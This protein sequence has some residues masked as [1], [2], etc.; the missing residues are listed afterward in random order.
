VAGG[1]E[2]SPAV[3][4][5]PAGPEPV[6]GSAL[7]PGPDLGRFLRAALVLGLSA[8]SVT[9]AI[10]QHLGASALGDLIAQN[11][12]A[13]VVRQRALVATLLVGALAGAGA[14]GVAWRRR[15]DGLEALERA[16]RLSSPGIVAALVPGLFARE[17]WQG[18]ELPLLVTVAA[19]S[20]LLERLLRR[21]FVAIPDSWRVAIS[22]ALRRV[23]GALRTGLPLVAVLGAAAYYLATVGRYTLV[24]HER[25]V[26]MSSDLAEFDNLFFNALSGH[27]FR[28]P[29]I[30]G[31]LENWS[32]LKVHAEFGLYLLL[33]FYA[34]K[35]GPEALLLIQTALVA[36][37]SIPVYLLAARRLGRGPG[38]VFAAAFLL[39]PV[40]QRPNFY[41]FHFTPLG[42][43]LVAWV[44]VALDGF[45]S[46]PSGDRHQRAWRI[47]LGAAFTVALLAREDI[48]IGL[49]VL[50]VFVALSGAH[51]RLGLGLA[52]A[53]TAYFGVIKFGV[54]PRFGTMWFDIIYDDLK[55]PG[56][57][58]FG[59]VIL[60]L[61]TN[62]LF[63]LR[64]LLTEA[65]LLYALHLTVPLLGL[66]LRRPGLLVAAA[67]GFVSTLLVTNR[68]PMY[69]SSFQYTY[70]WVP[71]IVGASILA[72]QW[73]GRDGSPPARARRDAAI[74][75]LAFAAV[76]SSFHHGALLGAE[77]ILGGFA[78]KRF[79]VSDEERQRL[80]E[81]RELIAAIPGDASVAATEAEGP[82]VSTRLVLYSLKFTLGEAPDYLVI[83]PAR[84]P[85]EKHHLLQALDSG[86]Y[87]VIDRSG[88]FWLV[89]RGA[90]PSM[91]DDLRRELKRAR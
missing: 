35:P 91:N 14:F 43:F 44:L 81:L 46:A 77:S 26:T 17:P 52:L 1:V 16:S 63:V 21:A 23:P 50:G 83:G 48:S 37:T 71:Y 28:A 25:M 61:L 24:S 40:V 74:A 72:V 57:R 75:A 9:L 2:S 10:A 65:K 20:L 34:L 80:S 38:V 51:L 7:P 59:A 73:L 29:A 49:A 60:T 53:A 82:H 22:A 89:Q 13:L 87:G 79:V 45:L 58:G 56:A 39:L 15:P 4:L 54:M 62:P 12:L 6:T 47:G 68:P 32:A 84:F 31:E 90:D 19:V 66:W 55:A 30:E 18:R 76:A 3:T 5:E 78:E 69:Q 70:L 36:M 41:D 88:P 8:A 11:D 67:P 33:P 42:M 27:P 86:E 64:S 85:S